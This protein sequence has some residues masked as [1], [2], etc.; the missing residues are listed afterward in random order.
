VPQL[1]V[2][3]GGSFN[4]LSVMIQ[5]RS[6]DSRLARIRSIEDAANTSTVGS[7]IGRRAF[8]QWPRDWAQRKSGDV[9]LR[10]CG[11]HLCGVL[12]GMRRLRVATFGANGRTKVGRFRVDHAAKDWPTN[13]PRYLRGPLF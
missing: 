9:Q 3:A 5:L 4:V 12:G 11:W 7:R 13:G 2:I 8:K 1:H 10:W 6:S